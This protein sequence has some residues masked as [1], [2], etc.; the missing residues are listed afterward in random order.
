MARTEQIG[1]GVWKVDTGAGRAVG[2]NV[3]D[4]SLGEARVS[5][6]RVV[7]RPG[8]NLAVRQQVSMDRNTRPVIYGR[9]LSEV[10]GA[11]GERPGA[12]CIHRL[13]DGVGSPAY[14]GGVSRR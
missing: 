11:R 5:R 4:V 10:S 12:R 3:D 2:R 9:P 8:Q 7:I 1:G 14:C 6:R 13:A